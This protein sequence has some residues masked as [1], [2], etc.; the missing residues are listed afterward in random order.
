MNPLAALIY[1]QQR[2]G[3][4]LWGCVF[5]TFVWVSAYGFAAA[6]PRQSDRLNFARTL[7]SNAGI[8]ALF[9]PARHIETVQG[10]TAWRCQTSFAVIG[11]VWGL[12]LATKILRGDE[13]AGRADLF[14]AGP[15]TRASGIGALVQG[16]GLVWAVLFSTV[17]LCIVSV[18]LIGG[19]F[20]WTAALWF[21]V[22]SCGSAAMF[23]AIGA[24]TSQLTSTRRAASAIGGALLG[25]AVIVRAIAE[26]VQ[27]AHWLRW[28]SPIGWLD[29]LH[30]LT[31]T[32]AA[33]LALVALV[34]VGAAALAMVLARR[35]DLGAGILP[36]RD[37]SDA[38]TALL[39]SP[40]RLTFRL[41][42]GN[43]LGW[44]VGVTLGAAVFGIVSSSISSSLADNKAVTDIFARLGAQLS[45]RGYVGITFVMLSALLA[46]TAAT[47][48]SGGRAEEADGRLEYL[49][50]APVL[51]WRW[52]GGRTMVAAL[53]LVAIGVVAG[54]GGW[55]GVRMSGGSISFGRMVLAG[56]NIVP[57]GLLVLGLG[58]LAHGVAAR[59]A[60]AVAYAAVAWSFLLEM[61]GA[62]VKLN[63]FVL[64]T[65][66]IHHIAAAPAADPR[67]DAALVM[68]AV[69]ALAAAGGAVALGRRDLVMA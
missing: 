67:W 19:Y 8:R 33:P 51:R 32:N 40:A 66:I 68:I 42:R 15:F 59:T 35:R 61:V 43:T 16:L 62:L 17:A 39:S 1:K 14:Y 34:A 41:T 23:L 44:M 55:V 5:G 21:A 28:A 9:G 57:P 4:V 29:K 30:P 27:G 47:F 63:H 56:L 50:S 65:S 58:T 38:H 26:S 45:A 3:A 48:V 20:S 11:A 31:G 2:R 6:Y 37:T 18:G 12:L 69:G 25:G 60:T 64:D 22:V 13:E 49:T 54:A 10:F 52:L 7:G 53:S 36:S 24:V 46:L